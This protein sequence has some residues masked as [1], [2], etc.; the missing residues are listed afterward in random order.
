[1]A[2]KSVIKARVLSHLCVHQAGHRIGHFASL[3]IILYGMPTASL[4]NIYGD[5]WE[6][7]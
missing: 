2:F 6:V 5:V 4:L 1:M 7:I 3:L